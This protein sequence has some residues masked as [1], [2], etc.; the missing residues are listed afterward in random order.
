MK[1]TVVLIDETQGSIYTTIL[2]VPV[3]ILTWAWKFSRQPRRNEVS[4]LH[5]TASVVHIEVRWMHV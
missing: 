5:D 1:V 3:S 4:L 2:P